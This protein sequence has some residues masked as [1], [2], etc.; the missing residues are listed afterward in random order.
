MAL[1]V[2]YVAAEATI[3]HQAPS[4]TVLGILV[5]LLI[6]IGMWLGATFFILTRAVEIGDKGVSFVVGFKRTH[7]KW[8]DLVPPRDAFFVTLTLKYKVDGKVQENDPMGV[9]K[10][11]ARAI[12]MH[13]KCP[14]FH[15]D[16]K[17]WESLG[18]P[19]PH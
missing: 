3:S 11:Q 13:P 12:M 1:G 5:G 6:A 18:L 17:I 14:K 15:M 7:V 16:P 9:S 10:A 19:V 2:A 8:N 4:V